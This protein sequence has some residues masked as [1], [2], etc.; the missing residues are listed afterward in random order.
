ME[1]VGHTGN[2]DN[3]GG[4]GFGSCSSYPV[5]SDDGSV[6]ADIGP[7]PSA[8]DHTDS[9][10]ASV[11]YGVALESFACDDD[12]PHLGFSRRNPDFLA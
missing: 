6:G 11:Q 8:C 10:D 12:N 1:P 5:G 9:N 3:H 2:S 7:E 4:N